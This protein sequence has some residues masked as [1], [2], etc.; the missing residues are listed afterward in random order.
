[1]KTFMD[2]R[3]YDLLTASRLIV[4]LKLINKDFSNTAIAILAK[5]NVSLNWANYIL[6][7]AIFLIDMK[8]FDKSFLTTIS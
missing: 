3:S 7:N 5:L 6:S 8:N 2:N 1:M 4:G